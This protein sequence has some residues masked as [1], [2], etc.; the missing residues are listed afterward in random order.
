M[1]DQPDE[2]EVKKKGDE[3]KKK[4]DELKK[5]G[6]DLQK[7]TSK[8]DSLKELN[9][10]LIGLLKALDTAMRAVEKNLKA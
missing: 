6:Q 10:I 3:L 5:I 2:K 1:P 4:A 8:G 7:L 9:S